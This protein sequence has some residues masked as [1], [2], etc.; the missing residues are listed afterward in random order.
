MSIPPHLVTFPTSSP[1]TA[2]N[3]PVN[4]HRPQLLGTGLVVV[5]HKRYLELSHFLQPPS[6]LSALAIFFLWLSG[7]ISHLAALALPCL[8]PV[9]S[10]LLLLPPNSDCADTSCHLQS[11][12]VYNSL[13]WSPKD[14]RQSKILTL[15]WIGGIFTAT[16]PTDS[17]F[18]AVDRI[19]QNPVG[20]S[21]PETCAWQKS[22]G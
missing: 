17:V 7:A 4:F 21:S 2:P 20:F 19:F 14:K 11:V 1:S 15:K 10:L 18:F 8:S 22:L 13:P 9:C 16:F 3:Y 5:G 12:P 6:R